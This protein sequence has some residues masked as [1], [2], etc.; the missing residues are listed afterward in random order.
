MRSGAETPPTAE[1]AVHVFHQYTVRATDRDGLAARSPIPHDRPLVVHVPA[2]TLQGDGAPQ[3]LIGI[4]VRQGD[5][6][7]E[8]WLHADDGAG[9]LEV[10]PLL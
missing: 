7:G 8:E 2:A 5:H 3:T 4:L 1:G 6:E 10:R 9:D